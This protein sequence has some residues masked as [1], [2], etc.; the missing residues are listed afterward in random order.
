VGGEE[1]ETEELGARGV[2]VVAVREVREVR[3]EEKVSKM[4]GSAREGAGFVG[5]GW[6][7]L[8]ANWED[9]VWGGF[10][11]M[12]VE[13]GRGKSRVG[14]WGE[15]SGSE[16]ERWERDWKADGRRDGC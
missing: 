12:V 10:I 6:E 2:G 8:W 14:K 9:W 13:V 4:G 7:S 16:P 3:G 1:G 5:S 11:V 15:G